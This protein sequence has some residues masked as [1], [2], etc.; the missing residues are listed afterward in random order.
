MLTYVEVL[1]AF[2][3]SIVLIVAGYQLYFLPQRL[4]IKDANVGTVSRYDHKFQFRPGWV[5]IY[6]LLYYPYVLSAIF[7]LSSMSEFYSTCVSYFALLFC[8]IGMSYLYPVRTPD[9]WRSYDGTCAS[10]RFLKFVQ[11]IDKGGNCFP[12]MHVAVATLT[13]I[14]ITTNSYGEL[15]F[16]VVLVWFGPA[17]IAVSALY[18]K[19]HFVADI[20]PGAVLACF[21]YFSYRWIL[22]GAQLGLDSPNPI[23]MAA[24]FFGAFLFIL[25]RYR[26]PHRRLTVTASYRLTRILV[27]ARENRDY[28]RSAGA[29]QAFV[30]RAARSE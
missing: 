5:W 23:L 14:H 6:S 19:Q 21:V 29:P 8:H 1:N 15:G 25:A 2:F 24:I 18:T 20:L 9:G 12:S 30:A 27:P 10:S 13:A 11:R 22:T 7:T 16:L 26:N 4:P 28:R 3:V 17:I